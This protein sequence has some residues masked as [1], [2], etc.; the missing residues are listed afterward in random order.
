MITIHLYNRPHSVVFVGN[1]LTIYSEEIF[2]ILQEVLSVRILLNFFVV[3][4]DE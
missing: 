1:F 4:F 3:L 2:K